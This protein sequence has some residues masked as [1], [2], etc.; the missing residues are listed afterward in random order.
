MTEAQHAP[1]SPL[2]TRGALLLLLFVSA[3]CD[4]TEAGEVQPVET[5]SPESTKPDDSAP[6]VI[7]A[8]W[9]ASK[10]EAPPQEPRDWLREIEKDPIAALK[11]MDPAALQTRRK[12]PTPSGGAEPET[13]E[14]RKRNSINYQPEQPL[15][16]WPPVVGKRY[17]NLV[18]R[19]QTGQVSAIGDFRGKVILVELVG[20][21]C[22]ACHA[23][24]GGNEP[25]KTRFR[26]IQPQAG[27]DSIERY[28]TSYAKLSLEH[29][30]IVF[31][32]LVLY[33]MDGRSPPTE[34]DAR[35]WASHFGMDRHENR[36]VLIGD[37]RFIGAASRR[38][39][40]GFHLIDRDGILRAMSSNDPKHDQLH[41]SLLPKLASLVDGD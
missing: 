14:V 34:N 30:D 9:V 24:A 38:L 4:R 27:L 32:Q 40:P 22:R 19:D 1:P 26:G 21:T 39:I 36:I 16:G 41:S 3:A 18:L 15:E 13:T 28:A 8:D 23:F 25:G 31:I 6:P 35:D 12:P 2:F 20:L 7:D 5:P 11:Q 29:P 17:P 33:G 37:Q 10:F